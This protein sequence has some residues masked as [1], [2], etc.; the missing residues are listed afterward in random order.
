MAKKQEKLTK[1]QRRDVARKLKRRGIKK[2]VTDGRLYAKELKR[3]EGEVVVERR[4]R[5]RK[6]GGATKVHHKTSGRARPAGTERQK[7]LWEML[8]GSSKW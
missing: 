6:T 8:T 5:L 1:R 2:G 7:S 3:A 4:K